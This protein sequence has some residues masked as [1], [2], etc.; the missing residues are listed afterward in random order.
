M[1]T[2]MMNKPIESGICN[3]LVSKTQYLIEKNNYLCTFK[4]PLK[5]L[6]TGYNVTGLLPLT[7]K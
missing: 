5:S 1:L 4:S 3:F 7:C 6:K 2:G